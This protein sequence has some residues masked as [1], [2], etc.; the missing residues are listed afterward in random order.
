MLKNF[1]K[2]KLGR[3]RLEAFYTQCGKL[4][5]VYQPD[6]E[7]EE[8]L[9]EFLVDMYYTLEVMLNKDQQKFTL[10]LSNAEALAFYQVWQM[11]PL[12]HCQY[13]KVIVDE[14]IKQIDQFHKSPQ[15]KY[16]YATN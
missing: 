14:A 6:N 10:N 8:L 13:T 9:R 1:L 11:V 12:D 16:R 4:M 2:I 5:E 7:H 15:N 3:E